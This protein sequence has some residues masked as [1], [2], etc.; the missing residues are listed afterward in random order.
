MH[1]RNPLSWPTRSKFWSALIA[2]LFLASLGTQRSSAATLQLDVVATGF[3]QPLF[4]TG[5]GTGGTRLFVVEKP[6]R[7][8]IVKQG[9]L[10][11]RPFLDITG[12]VNDNANERGLLGLAFHPTYERNGFFF[13]HYTD[14]SGDIIIAR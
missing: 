4:V 3:E 10:L 11:A 5:A 12:I 6:G 13:V 7:I 9:R 14:A 8:R 2:A 1:C